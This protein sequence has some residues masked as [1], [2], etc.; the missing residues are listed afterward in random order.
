[1]LSEADKESLVEQEQKF[2]INS[3]S[4]HRVKVMKYFMV[5]VM[6]FLLSPKQRLVQILQ[7]IAGCVL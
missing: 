2:Y 3:S 4:D 6:I 7:L 1:V 5:A